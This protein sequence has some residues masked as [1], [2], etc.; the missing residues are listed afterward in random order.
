M[1][2][3]LVTGERFVDS[4]MLT[5]SHLVAGQATFFAACVF[6]GHAPAAPEFAV[7]LAVSLMPD[8]RAPTELCGSPVFVAVSS[9]LTPLRASRCDPFTHCPGYHPAICLVTPVDS[10]RFGFNEKGWFRL[11]VIS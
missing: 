5:P 2:A 9:G 3:R 7:A 10:L 4:L 11:I 1:D 8:F 6:S